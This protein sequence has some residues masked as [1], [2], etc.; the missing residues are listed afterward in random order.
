MRCCSRSTTSR[1]R[2]AAG[3]AL[4]ILLWA[5]A[6][7]AV[8]ERDVRDAITAAV[9][10]QV[11]PQATVSVRE[12]EV[13]LQA[14]AGGSVFATLPPDAK[15]GVPM[16]VLLKAMRADGRATRFGEAQCVVDVSLPGV[17]MKRAVARGGILDG[18]AA[19]TVVVDTRGWSLRALPTDVAG[20]RAVVDLAAGQVVRRGMVVPAPLVRTGEPVTLAVVAGSLR[21]EARGVALQDGRLGDLVRVVNP[22]TGRR[23]PARVVGRGSVEVRHGT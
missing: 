21:V 1:G 11:G 19:E 20:A 8:D 2:L 4:A 10:R 15:A 6:G 3:L 13:R 18:T 9:A 23:V 16:R 22:D 7:A 14:D 5:P 12:L 17:R